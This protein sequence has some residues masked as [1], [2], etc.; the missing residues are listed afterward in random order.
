MQVNRNSFR[1]G[2]GLIALLIGLCL[3]LCARAGGN[4]GNITGLVTD[5][6]NQALSGVSV[7]A[8]GVTA[9]TDTTG[10]Y[11]L[12]S[13]SP[14]TQTVTASK[15]LYLS[16]SV[17]VTVVRRATVTAPTL[18]LA[19]NWGGLVGHVADASTAAAIVGARVSLSGTSQTTSTDSNGNYAFAQAPAGSQILTASASGYQSASQTVTVSSGSTTTVNL[20]LSALSISAPGSTI[21]WNGSSTYLLGSNYAWYNYGTDFGTGG[22]GKYTDWTSIRSGFASLSSQ[23][24]HVVRFWVFADGRYSPEFNS[25]GTVSGLDSYVLSDVDNI[26]QIAADTN[27]YL[28][29]TL[30]DNSIWNNATSSG[31]VIMGGHSALVTNSAVQQTY[32]DKA[33]KPLLQHVAASSNRSRVLGYDIVNEPE[34]NMAGYWGG[35]GLQAGQVQTFV[36]NCTSY[37]HAYG[38]GAYATVGSATPYYVS[39]WKNLGLDFYQ[40]H[41]YPW[42][43]FNNG[44]GSGLPTYASLNLDRP[45]IVGEFATADSSYNIGDSNPLSAQWYLDSI[46]ARGYAGALGWSYFV[47]DSASNW[48]SFQSVF[49]NWANTHANYI[50]PR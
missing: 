40:I 49:T 13:I 11:T 9:T 28:I 17:S 20:S 41:Y 35:V 22:W 36:Q 47:G 32:L 45:C 27:T 8:A 43:D 3:P 24:I 44:A 18:K 14:G 1:R 31:S 4:T 10:H 29:L 6:A 26:L 48:P 50:G 34:G 42:M 7:S 12:S 37:I 30:I 39:T 15:S 46:Y 25:D 19:P 5:T 23:G 38:G 16:A 33:L 21:P 2:A